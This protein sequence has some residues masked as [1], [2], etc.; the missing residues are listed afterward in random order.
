VK[1]RDLKEDLSP[2][3]EMCY[4]RSGCNGVGEGG[5]E[6]VREIL[7]LAESWEEF[8]KLLTHYVL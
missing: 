1:K 3:S 2:V 5:R 8:L 4:I 6:V 7:L